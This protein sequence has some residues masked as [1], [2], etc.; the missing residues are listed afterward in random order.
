MKT[1]FNLIMLAT[2]MGGAGAE[3]GAPPPN[4]VEVGK[5]VAESEPADLARISAEFE[6]ALKQATLS[7]SSSIRVEVKAVQDATT[8]LLTDLG[9]G[10]FQKDSGE[11]KAVS[12]SV[13]SALDKLDSLIDENY[14]W[15]HG[16]ANIS[17]PPE[18]P[19][20]ASGMNPQ[21]IRDPKLRQQYLNAIENEKSKQ[22]KNVQQES[23]K[24]AR[25]LI[26]LYVAALDSW[27]SAAGLSKDDLIG[28]F[29]DEGK[30]RELLHNLIMPEVKP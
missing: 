11:A 7:P 27:R 2:L 22:E 17:P 21:A 12:A 9:E 18:T 25:K 28:K 16:V 13:K 1:I 14:Q 24:S 4:M 19:N 26:L 23:L 5:A 3:V 15:Q 30:S 20:A 29:T 6:K 8:K 10:K